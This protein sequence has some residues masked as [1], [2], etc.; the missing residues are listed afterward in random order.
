MQRA[1]RAALRFYDGLEEEAF[2]RQMI[3]AKRLVVRLQ[4]RKV[5]GVVLDRPPGA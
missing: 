4:V 5:Y 1:A 2:Y 3:E